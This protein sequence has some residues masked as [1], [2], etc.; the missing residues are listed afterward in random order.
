MRP[1]RVTMDRVGSCSSRH[2]ITSVTSPK[3]QIMAMP[4][5]FSGSASGWATI[6]TSTPKSGVRTVVPEAGGEALVVGMGHQRH[7]GGHQLGAGGVDLD[8]VEAQAVVGAG[9]LAVLHLGLGHRRLVVDVPQ[10]RGLGRVGLAP[11]QVAQEHALAGPA[12]AVVDGGVAPGPVH[13]EAEPAPQ[14]LEGLLVLGRQLVAQGDEIGPADRDVL[15][16]RLVRRR[17]SGS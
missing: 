2:Q 13:R 7:A 17:K 5:P 8:V 15:L 12:A 3:V 16:P 9:P 11:G 4:D 10:R 6:G 1:A 14:R